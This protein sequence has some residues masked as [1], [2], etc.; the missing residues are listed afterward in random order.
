MKCVTNGN[1]TRRVTNE[2]AESLV[3]SGWNYAQKK[4]DG[5]R[6]VCDLCGQR[7]VEKPEGICGKKRKVKERNKNGEEVVN[8]VRCQ[9]KKF[10]L[11]TVPV[12]N[13]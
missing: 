10:S 11:R 4:H 13:W 6:F 1:E 9:S 2:Q 7:Y 12:R 5:E 8:E 3:K